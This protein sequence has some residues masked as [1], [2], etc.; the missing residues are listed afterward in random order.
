M[1]TWHDVFREYRRRLNESPDRIEHEKYGVLGN[2]ADD[3]AHA[4]GYYKGIM[5]VSEPRRSHDSIFWDDVNRKPTTQSGIRIDNRGGNKRLDRSS[6]TF[7]GRVWVDKEIISFWVYPPRG[8]LRKIIKDLEDAL[9]DYYG[10]RYNIT[11]NWKVD[12]PLATRSNRIKDDGRVADYD[13]Y[14]SDWIYDTDRDYS[15]L[16]TLDHILKNKPMEGI[17]KLWKQMGIDMDTGEA[18]VAS[19]IAKKVDKLSTRQKRDLWNYFKRL[20]DWSPADK[21][22]Y[23]YMASKNR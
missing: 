1:S 10:Y 9:H 8:R 4:F 11:P 6:F 20:G 23:N 19:P 7:P 18:H 14:E 17:G 21:A 16:Y 13:N 15:M 22:L 3:D 5:A 12:I 2:W